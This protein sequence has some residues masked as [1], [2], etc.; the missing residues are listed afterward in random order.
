M[1][2]ADERPEGHIKVYFVDNTY[3]TLPLKF[4]TTV[5]EVLEWV[6]KRLSAGGRHADP[7]RHELIILA[8]GNQTLRERRLLREDKP[9]QIQVKGAIAFKFLFREVSVDS[10]P[11]A[12][13]GGHVGQALGPGMSPGPA[14]AAM[15]ASPQEADGQTPE[16]TQPAGKQPVPMAQ[17]G[18]VAPMAEGSG[19]LKIG[20]L[21]RLMEDKASWYPCMVIL[22]EDRLWYS[23]APSGEKDGIGRY[24]GGMIFL[25]LC[26]C[27]KVME[28]D[29]KRLLQLLTKNG[30]MTLRAKNAH[31]RNSWLLAVVK[32]AALIKER[33]IL[34]QA[35]RIISG[36]EFRR[37]TQQ[38]N[39]L[40]ALGKLPTVLANASARELLFEFARSEHTWAQDTSS[41]GDEG[42]GD[43]S[44]VNQA[45]SPSAPPVEN[46]RH[47]TLP[48]SLPD[49]L[50]QGVRQTE[51][52]SLEGLISCL[53]RHAAAGHCAGE[54][55]ESEA[56]RI[57][58][59][60]AETSLFPRFKEHPQVQNRMCWIA[61]GIE[62]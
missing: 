44:I 49:G 18:A 43:H 41:D 42:A 9:L 6:C 27:D 47:G 15:S 33:D 50:P 60:F 30:S 23:P 38:I 12:E 59:A 2:G 28:G 40:E 1:L 36:M 46:A 37:A 39:K 56:D 34:F 57:A 26:D 51:G 22:D 53:Q 62:Y 52:L 4:N 45:A 5:S 13:D 25:P 54:A 10:S 48:A 16:E 3:K 14:P 19:R 61:A 58:W 20:T 24:G 21:E 8:P 35:E 32:Q 31:E 55:L 7:A 11:A 17:G 29:D